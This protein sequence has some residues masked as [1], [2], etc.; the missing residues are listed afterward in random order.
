MRRFRRRFSVD[1]G[2]PPPSVGHLPTEI[3]PNSVRV[4]ALS[5][6]GALEIDAPAG[7]DCSCWA[8]H[9]LA[10]SRQSN[11]AF[12][13]NRHRGTPIP[14]VFSESAAPI[15][16][17]SNDLRGKGMNRD[18]S[19]STDSAHIHTDDG[20]GH[21]TVSVQPPWRERS[22]CGHETTGPSKPTNQTPSTCRPPVIAKNQREEIRWIPTCTTSLIG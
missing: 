13:M 16:Q 5:S 19:V 6:Q 11:A 9:T 21:S 1:N 22:S 10:R 4:L 7:V 8:I 3:R 18:G 20:C 2:R 12:V 17:S 15:H 14:G